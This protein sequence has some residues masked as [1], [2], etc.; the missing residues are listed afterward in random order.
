MISRNYLTLQGTTSHYLLS[1]LFC[2]LGFA[3]TAFPWC[4]TTQLFNVARHQLAQLV[5]WMYLLLVLFNWAVSTVHALLC[6]DI[7]YSLH[8]YFYAHDVNTTTPATILPLMASKRPTI[9]SAQHLPL[10]AS[11]GAHRH[12][13]NNTHT[14][15]HVQL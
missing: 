11:I 10:K 14:A 3:T 9:Q 6:V 13:R 2:V 12:A 5:S 1:G 4:D 8:D 15:T 7:Y